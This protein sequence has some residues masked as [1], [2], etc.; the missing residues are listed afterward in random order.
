ML[1]DGNLAASAVYTENY[2]VSLLVEE[3][4]VQAEQNAA[5]RT[6]EFIFPTD[7]EIFQYS[8]GMY[9]ELQW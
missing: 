4:R 9:Q 6:P 5:L 7:A 3:K 8:F 2:F 1:I